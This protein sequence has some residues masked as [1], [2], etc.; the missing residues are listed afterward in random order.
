MATSHGLESHMWLTAIILY[1][2][3]INHFHKVLW[4]IAIK[5]Q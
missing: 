5:H 1:S 4:G 3:D 2:T